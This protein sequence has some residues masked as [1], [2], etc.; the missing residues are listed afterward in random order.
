MEEHI[1]KILD[2]DYVTD[3]VKR[4]LV[5]KPAGYTFEPGQATEVSINKPEWK[6]QRRPFTFTSLPSWKNLEFT[7][8]IY[9][10]HNGVTNQLEKLQSG[11]ELI[12]HDVFGAITYKGPGIFLAAGAGITPFIS[13]FRQLEK[14]EDLEKC[15]L[16]FSNKTTRDIILR[17]EF[18]EMLGRHFIN[19]ITRENVVGFLDRRIDE[20]F[21]KD[22]IRDFNRHFYICGPEDFVK[23]MQDILVNLGAKMETLVVEK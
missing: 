1:V 4:F 10:E 15:K 5:Q 2:S 6:D 11:D 12:L 7:I 16:V 18:E 23:A 8:K 13:I 19:V 21:L 3:D 22:N 14:N 17:K 9:R 20:D